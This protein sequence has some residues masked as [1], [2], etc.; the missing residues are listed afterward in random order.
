MKKMPIWI[1]LSAMG[2]IVLTSLAAVMLYRGIEQERILAKKYRQPHSLAISPDSDTVYF[3]A[4]VDDVAVIAADSCA[5]WGNALRLVES[6]AR[7][8]MLSDDGRCLYFHRGEDRLGD[9]TEIWCKDLQSNE[10]RRVVN[11]SSLGVPSLSLESIS[12]DGSLLLVCYPDYSAGVGKRLL[13]H[14]EGSP[15]DAFS[16]CDRAWFCGEELLVERRGQYSVVKPDDSANAAPKNVDDEIESISK[17]GRI[18]L[19]RAAGSP[20]RHELIQSAEGRVLAE[21]DADFAIRS[22]DGKL[23]AYRSAG[24]TVNGESAIALVDQNRSVSLGKL[25]E[26]TLWIASPGGLAYCNVVTIRVFD[27]KSEALRSYP[28]RAAAIQSLLRARPTTD[29]SNQPR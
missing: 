21:F 1:G 10:S 27:P 12:P 7:G 13:V 23:C 3:D 14:R 20:K 22:N 8:P 17:D 15:V 16:P 11:A 29:A 25:M 2:V 5:N 4:V 18:K 28:V 19:I 26:P 6:N 24:G 9:F